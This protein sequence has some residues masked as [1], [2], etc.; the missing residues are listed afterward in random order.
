MQCFRCVF[1]AGVLHDGD[2][3][4]GNSS[5]DNLCLEGQGLDSTIFFTGCVKIFSRYGRGNSSYE[6]DSPV[7]VFDQLFS[8]EA[9]ESSKEL[10]CSLVEVDS[11]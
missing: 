8:F 11:D 4:G 6:Q 1:F 2:A 7:S 5:F 10:V 9:V 3:S